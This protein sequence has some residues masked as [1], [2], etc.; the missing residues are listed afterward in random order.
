MNILRS[1]QHVHFTLQAIKSQQR[2]E[3]DATMVQLG[4]SHSILARR[5]AEHQG[6]KYIVIEMA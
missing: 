6:K 3:R 2:T 5:V 1:S 4:Q